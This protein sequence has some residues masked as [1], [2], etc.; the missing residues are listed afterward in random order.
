MQCWICGDEGTTGEHLTKLSDLKSHF[1]HVSQNSPLY[2]HTGEKMNS[3]LKS[4][5]KDARLKS[6]ALICGP[7]NNAKTSKYDRAWEKLSNYLRQKKPPIRKGDIIK[8]EKV[9][10]GTV[11]R[12]MLRVHLFFVKLFGCAIVAYNVPIDIAPLRNGLLQE[13]PV[14]NVY[15][16]F[17]SSNGMG[18]GY[19]EMEYD[20]VGGKCTY[21]T[22]F[23]TIGA[24]SV[25]VMYALPTE[26]RLGLVGSWHPSNITK[27]VKIAGI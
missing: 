23:Y 3:K 12:S 16:A 2:F 13:K 17:W 19:S 7:C 15:L 27:R 24:V 10:P 8:L 14:N 1:G 26:N 18:D 9:F 4:I 21:A 22:W 11:K 6:S 20:T 25:N 5:K